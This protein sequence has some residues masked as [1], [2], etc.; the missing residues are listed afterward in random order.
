MK[1]EF[2]CGQTPTHS[3]YKSC[4][5]R[6]LSGIDFV[7]N[8]WEI[9]QH[10]DNGVVEHIFSRHFFEHLTFIQGKTFISVCWDILKPGGVFEVVVPNM[11]FHI[12]QWISRSNT[13]EFDWAK[14]GFW[15]HQ[16]DAMTTM[17]DVHKSGYDKSTLSRLLSDHKFVN[18][19]SLKEEDSPHLQIICNK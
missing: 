7:C 19:N 17:W 4:D 15:G 18:I 2:G 6:N 10:V 13:Q 5:V 16:R 11:T 9:N 12:N 1:I 3:D 8:A 14:A